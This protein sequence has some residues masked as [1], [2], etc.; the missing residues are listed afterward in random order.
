MTIIKGAALVL[1]TIIYC[2]VTLVTL[3]AAQFLI[4]APMSMLFLVLAY[5]G[6]DLRVKSFTFDADDKKLSVNE[7]AANEC[8]D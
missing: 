6:A 5:L 8:K 7:G 3:E 2:R 4:A 1:A